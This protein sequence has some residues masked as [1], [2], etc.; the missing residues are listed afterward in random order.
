MMIDVNSLVFVGLNSRVAALDSRSGETVW[1]WVAP[2]PWSRG[3]VSLLLLND[4]QL[5]VSANG[6]TYCLDPRT[7]QQLWANDLSG[8]GT[9]VASIAVM[10]RHSPHDVVLG[11]ASADARTREA[12]AATAGS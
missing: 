9:G 4:Q 3:Y 11:A 10:G 8:F 12:G 2:K 5:I 6:Y 1:T 7:G